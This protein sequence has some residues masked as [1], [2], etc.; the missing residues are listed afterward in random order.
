MRIISLE[1]DLSDGIKIGDATVLST[2]LRAD[3][4]SI[5]PIDRVIIPDE[6]EDWKW[7]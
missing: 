2:A 5:Y 4:G 7:E 1:I 3:N 6:M